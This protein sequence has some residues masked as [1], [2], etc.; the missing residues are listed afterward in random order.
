VQEKSIFA[1]FTRLILFDFFKS[2]N[3]TVYLHT[4]RQIGHNETC[5]PLSTPEVDQ[6]QLKR[7]LIQT[8]SLLVQA[9]REAYTNCVKF[10]LAK[11][12]T[13]DEHKQ[14]LL[15]YMPPL[16]RI[17]S[18]IYRSDI[19]RKI[20]VFRGRVLYPNAFLIATRISLVNSL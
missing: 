6:L 13:D 14:K 4:I 20:L 1:T 16:K 12:G 3:T 10:L 5:Q 19:N 9:P 11:Y 7:E 2:S 17:R 18:S 8:T 15:S